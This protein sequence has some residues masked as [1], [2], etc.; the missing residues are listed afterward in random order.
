MKKL[1]YVFKLFEDELSIIIGLVVPGESLQQPAPPFPGQHHR[2][3]L[4]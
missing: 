4:L 3:F 2:V 1:K